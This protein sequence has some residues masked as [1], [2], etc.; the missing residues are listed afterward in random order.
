MQYYLERTAKENVVSHNYAD[1]D[2]TWRMVRQLPQR[3]RLTT[4][5]LNKEAR[6]EGRDEAKKTKSVLHG[7]VVPG[8][9]CVSQSSK[10]E[11]ANELPIFG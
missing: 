8:R 10:T 7:W 9:V 6:V 2:A 4:A 5:D 1:A 3:G 11:I